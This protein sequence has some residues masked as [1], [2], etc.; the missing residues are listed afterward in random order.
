[1]LITIRNGVVAVQSETLVEGQKLLELIQAPTG[2]VGTE[3]RPITPPKKVGRPV[4]SFSRNGAFNK[5]GTRRRR[6]HKVD[7]PVCSRSSRNLPNHMRL[8]HLNG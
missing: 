1:M 6:N 2:T 5:D 4:G 3:I 7:C 8:S